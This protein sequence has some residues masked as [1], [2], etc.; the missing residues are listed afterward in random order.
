MLPIQARAT[1]M[2][3]PSRCLLTLPSHSSVA[4]EWV[5]GK[6]L[7]EAAGIKNSEI[8]AHLK[9]PPVKLHCSML[10]ESA[11]KAAIKDYQ[12]KSPSAAAPAAATE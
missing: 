3:A 7:D 11:I 10:A 4:T 8:A 2:H 6:T 9:L 12:N 5:K 1:D